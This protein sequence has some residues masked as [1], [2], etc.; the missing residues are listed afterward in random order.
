MRELR[1]EE[2]CIV[3]G[4]GDWTPSDMM[5]IGAGLG[6]GITLSLAAS[7]NL[8]ASQAAL[9]AGLGTVAGA[10]ITAAAISGWAAGRGLNNSTN[11]QD[12]IAKTLDWV[13]QTFDSDGS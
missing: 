10:A 8:S 11:V 9:I 3:S 2:L 5:A 6:G 12:W 1:I 4:G 7:F 13:N